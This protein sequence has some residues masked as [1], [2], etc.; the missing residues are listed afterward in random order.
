MSQD[1]AL[2][3][4]FQEADTNGN[5]YLSFDEFSNLMT[6]YGYRNESGLFEQIFHFVDKND[7]KKITLD[8]F[9]KA[10]NKVSL[11]DK[12]GAAARKTFQM[13][14]KD[15][16]GVIDMKELKQTSKELGL[17]KGEVRKILEMMG[18]RKRKTIN[19]E[20]FISYMNSLWTTRHS[21]MWFVF[22]FSVYFLIYLRWVNVNVEIKG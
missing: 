11:K 4:L 10:M 12:K 5:G 6:K 21:R 18:Q 3:T 13:F 20:E 22:Y 16:N 1:E 9:R 14:D 17:T 8:E 7:D 15:K 2:I 19:Y